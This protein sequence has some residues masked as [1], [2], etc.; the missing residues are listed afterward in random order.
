MTRMNTQNESKQHP[1]YQRHKRPIFVLILLLAAAGRI[2]NIDAESL[3]VDEGFG[4]WAIRHDDM[5]NLILRDVH[6]PVYFYGLRGWASLA[7]ISELALRYFSVIPSLLSVAAIMPLARELERLRG[8]KQETIVPLL[9]ALMLTLADMEIYIAQETRMYSWH[10]LWAIVSMWAFLRFARLSNYNHQQSRRGTACRAPTKTTLVLWLLS[11]TL[12]L[13]TQ[14]VGAAMVAVQGLYALVFLR[15]RTRQTAI[16]TLLVIGLLFVPW[17]LVVASNQ[18]ENVGTG[19]SVPSTLESLW[20]WRANWFTGQWSLMLLLAVFG[21]VRLKTEHQ[22]TTPTVEA[23]HAMPLPKHQ[24]SQDDG[25]FRGWGF[26]WRPINTSFLLLLWVVVPVTG[27]Y[28]LNHY[29]PILMHYRLTQIT[30]AIALLF[31]FGLGNL[32][33]PAL[34]LILVAI[35]LYGIT[36]DDAAF[37]RP[38]WREVGQNAALYAVSGDLALA[39]ITP[40]GDWQVMYYYERFMPEGVERRSLRQWQL[41]QGDT[42]AAGLPALLDEYEHVWFMQWSKDQ[43]GFEALAATGYTQTAIMTEHWLENDLSVF[44]FDRVPPSDDAIT[45]YDNGMVLRDAALH[46]ELL[47]V[48]LWWSATQ[49]LDRNYTISVFLLA[50]NGQL[51]AQ[52]DAY[53]FNNARPTASWQPDEVVYDPHELVLIEGLESLPPGSYSAAVKVYLWTGDGIHDILT[54]DGANSTV[55]GTIII[56]P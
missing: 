29:T 19:F 37:K 21:L 52:Y 4:Y 42:Y 47:R 48:D 30:P 40:S 38:P 46:P 26:Q 18:T 24:S 27:A 51:L 7:G 35:L 10:V 41:E 50:D 56:E 36:T 39:H 44:R 9:A 8:N 32:R 16:I 23:Q 20:D 12:L 55:I 53:P 49:T 25:G 33:P 22:N 54:I 14:Y 45:T 31:A 1:I 34:R 28:I 17:L 15:N 11:T 3:W 2:L 43:S 5:F 6:P 13:Y